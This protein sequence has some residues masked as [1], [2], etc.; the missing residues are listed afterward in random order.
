MVRAARPPRDDD[1]AEV[2]G[3]VVDADL[4]GRVD[5]EA[6]LV[7]EER[8]GLA[9]GARAEDAV[10]V[11]GRREAED[12]QGVAAAERADDEVVDGRRVLDGG[13]DGR[14]GGVG[15]FDAEGGG[16]GRRVSEQK[17]LEGGVGPGV[18][19]DSR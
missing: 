16:G 17:V 10:L 7:P 12:R 14:S 18:A 15:R 1:V 2:R 8:A 5:V 4:G 9:D 13:E 3:G 19:N 11:P 6:E